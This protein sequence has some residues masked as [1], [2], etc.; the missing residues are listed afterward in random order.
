[1]N[2]KKYL[3][4]VAVI[5]IVLS[6]AF[7]TK[8]TAQEITTNLSLN[9]A[10]TA[11]LAAN[12]DLQTS[13][14]D[15]NIA[16]AKYKQTQAIFLPQVT[17]SYS[18][19]STDN[20]LNAFGFNLQQRT[21]TQ[22]DFN[23]D[24]LN[25]PSGTTDFMG[26]LE[27][28]QPLINLDLLYKRKGAEKQTV[29]YKFKT[30]RT[31]EYLTFEVQK[32]YLQLQL[33]FEASRV[34]EDALKT[35][36][37]VY[38]FT[39]NH[40]KQGLIQKT[41]VLNARVH[42]TTLE[43]NLSK[44]KSGISNASDYLSLLMGKKTGLIYKTSSQSNDQIQES[45]TNQQID[46]SRADFMA[47]QKAIES[48]NLMIKSTRMSYLPKLNAFGNYQYNDSQL[49]GFGAHSYFAGLQLSWDIF[50]GGKTK[51]TI[52]AQRLERDKLSIQL[53]QQKEQSQLD[54]DKSLRA[55]ADA[56]YEILQ[57]MAS[58]EQSS[59]ALRI[60]QNRYQQGLENTTDVLMAESQLSQQKFDLAQ[61]VF[62]S[63]VTKAYV[64]F[65]TTSTTK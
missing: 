39:D 45:N 17:A 34:L 2:R 13:E 61:A 33:A 43:S 5:C 53:A 16:L 37:S 35:V 65:L 52:V 64:Q 22:N 18:A 19:M 51:N 40:F 15:E 6:N 58:I 1:M 31:K 54:L 42:V 36:K 50:K 23:P 56:K 41:D 63:N 11:A 7:S 10:I 28:Q 20:P 12:K 48:S 26:K 46:S 55:L 29:L 25:H 9:E 3:N 24:L 32:A 4:L 14:L 8:T 57:L 38:N 30:L 47:M 49:T 44:S 59:E 27:V 60:L 62:T 21:I